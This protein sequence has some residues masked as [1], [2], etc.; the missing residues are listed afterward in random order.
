[1]SFGYAEL[2]PD[3][4]RFNTSILVDRDGKIVG[5]Y[6]KVH[7]PG[8][9]EFEPAARVPASGEALLRAGRSRL[10]GLAHAGRH[11]RHVHLQRPPLARDLSRDGP[12]GRRADRARLQHAV[13]QLAEGERGP[14]AAHVPAPAVAAGR[15]L[16]E[17]DLGGG[18]GEVRRRGRASAVRRQHDR[19]PGWR[20]R[21][22]GDR[23]RT[24]SWSS[25]TAISTRPRS[26][27]RRC[28]TSRATAASSITAAS[29]A[30]PA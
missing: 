13:G 23:P 25:P 15:R 11:S 27:R 16:P 28:S 2:T 4:H 18:D 29:P 17:F 9:A 30:R 7:L 3:G 8:H 26:A 19:Q 14:G 22:G 6:R 10:P 12:A 24:T 20:D 1:M 21:R 5:K